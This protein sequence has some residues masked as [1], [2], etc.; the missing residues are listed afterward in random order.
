L[1]IIDV[2]YYPGTRRVP[3]THGSPTLGH[4]TNFCTNFYEFF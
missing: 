3:G 1:Q 2:V 4:L